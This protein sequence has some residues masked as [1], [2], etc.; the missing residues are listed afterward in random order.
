MAE[1]EGAHRPE[2]LEQ[3]AAITGYDYQGTVRVQH[4]VDTI[5][6][7]ATPDQIAARAVRPLEGL[8][9]ACYYGCLITRPAQ[10]TGAEHPEYPMQMDDLMRALGAETVDWSYKTDCCGGSLSVTQTEQ[11]LN[12]SQAILEDARACGADAVITMCPMCHMNLDARQPDMGERFDMPVFHSTQLTTLAFG[13]GV[14][15][16]RFN[17]N[18]VDPLPLLQSKGLA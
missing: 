7:H 4:F 16:S 8:K 14:K 17:K 9:L 2:A 3:T 13:L 18:I 1:Y 5:L 11:S 12:M 15:Q 6:D 10:A